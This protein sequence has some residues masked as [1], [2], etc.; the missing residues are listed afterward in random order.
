MNIDSPNG[1]WGETQTWTNRKVTANGDTVVDE[2]QDYDSYIKKYFRN[3]SREDL[4]GIDTFKEY[5]STMFHEKSF[6]VEVTDG[7]L[8]LDFKP[9]TPPRPNVTIPAPAKLSPV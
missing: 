4:P 7:K 9:N 6:D 8:E 2:K 1:F 3:A 5:I